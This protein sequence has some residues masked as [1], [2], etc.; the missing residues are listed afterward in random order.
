M[1][2]VYD[3][4]YHIH[5]QLS[6]CSSDPEQTAER[7]LEYARTNGLKR[8]VLT[9]HHWD[10]SVP[11]ASDWYRPQD[12]PWI[13]Q[14]KPL[15]QDDGIEFLFGCECDMDRFFTVGVAR[16]N[17]DRFDFVIIPTTHLHMRGFTISEEDAES[18]ERRAQLWVERLDAL[19][20][21][22]LPFRKIGI[23]HLACGLM[24][25]SSRQ[26][27]LTVMDMI[28]DADM[29]RLFKKAAELGVG[30]ELNSS[31]MSFSDAEEDT[32]L[33]M[34]R[35]AKECGC[36]FYF[37]SDAHHPA[38]LDKAKPIFERA[39]DRLGLTEDDKFHIGE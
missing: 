22:D 36:K 17:F 16:E 6:S 1:R 12:Y 7:I 21:K 27:Y 38:G 14:S 35:I 28:P 5:S 39:I 31:D 34:F 26:D 24:A 13:C 33:R 11:G 3:H 23:A 18:L 10:E 15:P 19:L 30:I 37:G 20:S 4:D 2:Y 29:Y 32:V 8:L 25:N 9:D